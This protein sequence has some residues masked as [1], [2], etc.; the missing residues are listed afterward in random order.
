ME[1]W[2]TSTLHSLSTLSPKTLDPN[3]NYEPLENTKILHVYR[4]VFH[5]FSTSLTLTEAKTLKTLPG[6]LSVIPDKPRQLHTTRTP[7]FLGLV[8]SQKNKPNNLISSSNAGEGVII[9]VLDTGINPN[10]RSFSNANLRKP[11]TKWKGV[12]QAGPNFPSTSCNNKLV[13]AQFFPSGFIASKSVNGS[14]NDVLSPYDSNGHGTHTT[15]TASGGAISGAS[16]FGFAQGVATGIAPR[17]HVAAYKVCWSSGC[18]ESDILA[19]FDRAVE[20]GA[21]IISLSVGGGPAPYHMDP[22]AIGAFSASAIH[23]VLISAS[24]GN[25]GPGDMT[26]TNIAP[27]ITTVGASTIDRSFPADI[28]LGDG[29]TLSGVSLYNTKEISRNQQF[30]LVY[31]GNL[32]SPRLGFRSTAP[33]CMRGS[34]DPEAT[35]GKVVLC[36]RGV[37]PR[38]EKGLAVKEAGGLGIIIANQF[39]DGEGVVPDAHLIPAVEIGYSAGNFIHAYIRNT[40]S[41][42]VSLSFHGTQL[43]I[44]PAPIV[45]SFSGRGPSAQSQYIIKPDLVA[46]GVGILAAWTSSASPTDL[47]SDKRRTEFNILSGTSMACPHV[48]GVATLIKAAHPDWSPAAI[49]SAMMTTAYVRDSLGGELTDESSGNRSVEWA[50]GSGH[51]D[52][53]KANDPGLVYDLSAEDYINFL[54]NSNYTDLDIRTIT[55]SS[56]NCSSRTSMPWDLNYPSIIVM[57]NQ[58]NNTTA[59]SGKL[60]VIV[61]RTLTSVQD[62]KSTYAVSVKEP[63]GVKIAVEPEKLVFGRKGDKQQFII[64]VSADLM[65]LQAGVSRTEFGEMAW[66]DGK[67]QVRSPLGFTW[68]QPY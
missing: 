50:H 7:Q 29:T 22:I 32:S 56:V 37:V 28:C 68:H 12:C 31:A 41:P 30:P 3:L 43:G 38:V 47:V 39:L 24:S 35:R 9:A 44:K 2:Y 36:E 55:R 60:D 63:T 19:A 13:G 21:D 48:S 4:T 67:H 25:D 46:P 11:P 15:S 16:F 27:W 1:A 45:A 61:R 49:R 8:S 20:D 54:C 64:R 52:P 58:P 23:K 62:E 40:T 51:V 5:G 17:A 42:K 65:K 18:F 10:H 6:V 66:N 57:M 14:S 59:V 33:F 53:E 26:A 34:L